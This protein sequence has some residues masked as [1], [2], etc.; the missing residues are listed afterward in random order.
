MTA[1]IRP[2][3]RYEIKP[4]ATIPG[5][6]PEWAWVY[7][8]D[9]TIYVRPVC[10]GDDVANAVAARI[11]DALQRYDEATASLRNEIADL[12]AKLSRSDGAL[13]DTRARL[14]AVIGGRRRFF[15]EALVRVADDGAVWL[16]DPVKREA[17]IGLR[18]SSLSA[19]WREHPELRPVR[20]SGGDL[21][22]DATTPIRPTTETP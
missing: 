17:G 1:P 22:V 9:A 4:A 14:D 20:W 16:L 19:L 11:A 15:G 6:A 2:A 5:A 21:I 10:G 7:V 12:R 13:K 3:S 8:D 18:F